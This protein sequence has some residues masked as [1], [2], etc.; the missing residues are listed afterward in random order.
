MEEWRPSTAHQTPWILCLLLGAG[1]THPRPPWCTPW[2]SVQ[3]QRGEVRLFKLSWHNTPVCRRQ[4]PRKG[5][6]ES[7]GTHDSRSSHFRDT[8]WL[9]SQPGN[10]RQC[11]CPEADSGEVPGTKQSIVCHLRGSDKSIRY[12]EQAGTLENSGEARLPTKVP[13]HDH[14]APWRPAWSQT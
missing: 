6:A 3:E 7:T 11:V 10:H 4:N 1:K 5:N 12:R 9:Q 13:H 14:P 8:V 2:Y